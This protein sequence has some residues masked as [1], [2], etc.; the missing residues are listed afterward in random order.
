MV[1]AYVTP[2]MHPPRSSAIATT[3]TVP[4]AS[5]L[6]NCRS[7]EMIEVSCHTFS[8]SP[9]SARTGAGVEDERGSPSTPNCGIARTRKR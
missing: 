9:C 3:E 8:E 4:L 6:R 2:A 1:S 5:T 7:C